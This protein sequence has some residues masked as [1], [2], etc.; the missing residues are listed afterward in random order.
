MFLKVEWI[1]VA[2]CSLTI[3]AGNGPNFRRISRHVPT[4]SSDDVADRRVGTAIEG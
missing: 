1:H 2:S 3:R 4:P